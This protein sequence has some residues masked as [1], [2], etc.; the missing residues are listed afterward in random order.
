MARAMG[1]GAAGREWHHQ[2]HVSARI[3]CAGAISAGWATPRPAASC[4]NR[5]R[6]SFTVPS[7]KSDGVGGAPS[8]EPSSSRRPT[9]VG[10]MTIVRCCPS[11]YKSHGNVL[12]CP[13]PVAEPAPSARPA[14]ERFAAASRRTTFL[15]WTSL[16]LEAA[17]RHSLSSAVR[18]RHSAQC[19]DGLAVPVPARCGGCRAGSGGA[20][21]GRAVSVEGRSGAF[22][23]GSGPR[24]TA[25]GPPYPAIQAGR[26]AAS[27]TSSPD[28]NSAM[29]AVGGIAGGW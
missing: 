6:R 24:R 7:R 1:R 22:S 2:P 26:A 10:R 4:R 19:R 16:F 14:G 13:V 8:G 17:A 29:F 5:R 11:R 3:D 25:V 18:R 15:A 28:R 12:G 20:A 9:D 27:P 23:A 21:A